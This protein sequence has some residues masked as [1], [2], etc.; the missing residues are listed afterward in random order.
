MFF[1]LSVQFFLFVIV[2]ENVAI[3]QH[4]YCNALI[5]KPN[6]CLFRTESSQLYCF[7]AA[8]SS[9]YIPVHPLADIH[10]KFVVWG[11]KVL[12]EEVVAHRRLLFFFLI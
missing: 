3:S 11:K 8:P 12:V 7:D 9:C 5:L 10:T 4:E 6:V 2:E 1:T